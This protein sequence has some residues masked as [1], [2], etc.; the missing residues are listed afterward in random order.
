MGMGGGLLRI[1]WSEW[2]SVSRDLQHKKVPGW[3]VRGKSSSHSGNS[4]CKG[5]E[6]GM[7]FCL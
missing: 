1:R 6:V 4:R 7:T 3:K 2:A 5:P